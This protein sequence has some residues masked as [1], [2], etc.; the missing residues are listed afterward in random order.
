MHTYRNPHAL[1]TARPAPPGPRQVAAL[2]RAHMPSECRSPHAETTAGRGST[3]SKPS[4]NCH[5]APHALHECRNPHAEVTAGRG[6]T[7]S[8]PSRSSQQRRMHCRSAAIRMPR[9]LPGEAP[10]GTSQVAASSSTPCTARVPQSACRFLYLYNL[11]TPDR[12]HARPVSDDV[13]AKKDSKMRHLVEDL[14]GGAEP[15]ACKFKSTRLHALLPTTWAC[16]SVAQVEAR[17]ANV[18]PAALCRH[19]ARLQLFLVVF[20]KCARGAPRA[21]NYVY[22]GAIVASIEEQ[23]PARQLLLFDSQDDFLLVLALHFWLDGN[24]P[25]E[26]NFVGP[27]ATLCVSFVGRAIHYRA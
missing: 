22:G 18:C 2:S 10:S 4:H 27:T 13:C 26:T 25:Q 19:H 21:Q 17:E 12:P 23:H 1:A 15:K 20:T 11:K 6:A 3:R 14:G 5:G 16:F 7:R 24:G 9:K 8:K